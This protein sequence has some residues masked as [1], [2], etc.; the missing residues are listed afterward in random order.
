MSKP[1]GERSSFT[2]WQ[3]LAFDMSHR[4]YMK[5]SEFKK[6]YRAYKKKHS[7]SKSTPPLEKHASHQV[8]IQP[9]KSSK[10]LA[11]YFCLDC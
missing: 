4:T 6:Q 7:K 5:T 1:R 11:K 10:H 2:N 3:T 9:V 8:E